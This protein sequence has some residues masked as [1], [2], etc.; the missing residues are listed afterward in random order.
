MNSRT[1]PIAL[2]ALGGLLL[3]ANNA[4]AARPAPAKQAAKPR[5]GQKPGTAVKPA[6]A[7]PAAAAKNKA[8]PAKTKVAPAGSARVADVLA[9]LPLV[10]DV[11]PNAEARYF[12]YLMSAGWCGPCNMEMPHIVKAYEEIRSEGIVEVILID[13]DKKPEQARAYMDKY[14]ATFPAVMEGVAPALP[15]ILPPQGIPSAIIVDAMGNMVK[16]GHG[17][18]TRQWRKHISEY[19]AQKGLPPSFP[20]ASA[21]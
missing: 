1:L 12:V 18:I 6:T 15:G 8:T 19:E 14:G 20:D 7:E 4:E 21:K 5:A 11:K 13:F 9:T 3:S 17:S 16:R 10:K 2:L